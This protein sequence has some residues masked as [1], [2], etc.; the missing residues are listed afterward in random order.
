[1]T[2]TVDGIVLF[3]LIYAVM[4]TVT[5]GLLE[6]WGREWWYDTYRR[7]LYK[8]YAYVPQITIEVNLRRLK[9]FLS[10]IWP[11]TLAGFLTWR[12]LIRPV[13]PVFRGIYRVSA[14]QTFFPPHE[15]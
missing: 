13:I 1:M 7:I 6:R 5:A 4:A 8:K 9:I 10:V 11:L 14:G 15:E 12:L 2:L 3:I